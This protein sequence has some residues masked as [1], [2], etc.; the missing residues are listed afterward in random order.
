M[1]TPMMKQVLKNNGVS[2]LLNYNAYLLRLVAYCIFLFWAAAGSFIDL[3]S[4]SQFDPQLVSAIHLKKELN[5]SKASFAMS[6]RMLLKS[7]L[8][9][10]TL[11]KLF[12]ITETQAY[13]SCFNFVFFFFW[14]APMVCR[15][16]RP[17]VK[18][19]PQQ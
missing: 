7:S 17:G 1:G 5:I 2:L 13:M 11:S 8:R 15:V 19:M 9:F 6:K 3:P 12:P 4:V 16:P 18:P 14:A 10:C